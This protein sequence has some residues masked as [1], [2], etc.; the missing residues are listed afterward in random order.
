MNI[1]S[2]LGVTI[3]CNNH[4]DTLKQLLTT[5]DLVSSCYAGKF[6]NNG[7][8]VFRVSSSVLPLELY[9][10]FAELG[11]PYIMMFQLCRCLLFT[12]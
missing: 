4:G 8:V 6:N 10:Q 5:A 3:L 2:V 11:L 9:F 7:R 1:E 12:L